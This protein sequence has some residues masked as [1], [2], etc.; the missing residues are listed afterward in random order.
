MD[1]WVFRWMVEW[2]GGWIDRYG[3]EEIY[4]LF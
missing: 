4:I 3:G 1:G 2:M